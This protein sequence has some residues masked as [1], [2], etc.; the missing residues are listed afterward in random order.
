[1]AFPP[2][3]AA[4]RTCEIDGFESTP[5]SAS[6]H[7]DEAASA[8]VRSPAG[9]SLSS[10]L[11]V[12]LFAALLAAAIPELVS[13]AASP[14]LDLTRLEPGRLHSSIAALNDPTQTYELYLPSSFDPAMRWPLLFVFDPR[15]RGRLAAELFVPA[16][17]RWGWIVASSNDTRSDGPMEPNQRALDA[18][19][20][21][22]PRRLPIDPKRIYAG[23]FSGGAV[24][25]WLVGVRSGQLAGV[26]SVGGRPPSEPDPRKP[27]FA[28]WATAGVE[29][30]NHDP[31]RALDAIA[32]AAGVPHRLEFF[33]GPHDWFPPAA[34]SR[35]V[36]WMEVVAMR[37][38]L[39]PT[40]REAVARL[41]ADDLDGAA[42]LASGGD[43][44]AAWRRYQA[45]ADT[46][47]GLAD[48]S[49]AER[50]AAE[51][52]RDR[53]VLRAL[54]DEKKG[55]R[56][57]RTA[58]DRAA[59]AGSAL[60]H[61]EVVPPAARLASVMGLAAI[62]KE[63]KL[64]GPRGEA[65]R[66]ARADALAHFAFYL[67]RDLRAAQES[68]RERVSLELAVRIAPDSAFAWYNL[69][70]ASARLGRS[71]DALTEL[72]RAIDLD[73]RSAAH[74]AEDPNLESLRETARYREL[75]GKV[76]PPPPPN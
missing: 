33:P 44:L 69:A 61:D 32:A 4:L 20:P 18:M 6:R 49:T 7:P 73:P 52:G 10:R 13:A 25:A 31:T 40:D 23:G 42:S 75:L 22:L 71:A 57:E 8:V 76:E 29:D 39:R 50:R 53:D 59:T 37:Q 1:M 24:L 46:Y 38:G 26:I 14:A 66:R 72:A 30:F 2:L 54:E 17:E 3:V 43:R 11:R 47:R 34:A 65:A 35:A 19:W 63:A 5:G 15:S 45:I 64:P 12:A 68:S 60:A 27:A 70:C 9:V 51:L 58:R 48:V 41:L 56:F 16:A 21:D 67:P 62:E 55:E 36:A 74:M 28:L